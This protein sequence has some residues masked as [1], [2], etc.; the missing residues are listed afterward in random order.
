[1]KLG[2]GIY[3]SN[4]LP[5]DFLLRYLHIRVDHP[6]N[7]LFDGIALLN[8]SYF[9]IDIYPVETLSELVEAISSLLTIDPFSVDMNS[10][11][12]KPDPQMDFSDV[13]GQENVKRAME[14]AAAGGHNMIML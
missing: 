13:R 1:M 5:F 14:I 12:D 3:H 11:F 7:F 9:S 4:Y 10:L 6:F 2:S 8:I